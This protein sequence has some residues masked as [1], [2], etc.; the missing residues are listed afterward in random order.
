MYEAKAQKAEMKIQP[1]ETERL[2]DDYWGPH[3]SPD[4]THQWGFWVKNNNKKTPTKIQIGIL[5]CKLK[6][7]A[8]GAIR[9]FCCTLVGSAPAFTSG[10]LFCRW[11][12]YLPRLCLLLSPFKCPQRWV[13]NSASQLWD[14]DSPPWQAINPSA[15]SFISLTS[16]SLSRPLPILSPPRPQLGFFR[17]AVYYRIMPKHQGVKIRRAERYQFNLGFQPED[18]RK[19]YWITNWT[20]MQQYYYWGL[21][22]LGPWCT[23]CHAGLTWT[24]KRPLGLVKTHGQEAQCT[25]QLWIVFL[26]F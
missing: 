20:E 11:F 6:L 12:S 17:R 9:V 16:P 19:K 3:G 14:P 24:L 7:W 22:P 13:F 18:S 25:D 26:F 5:L 2:T 4:S 1:S 21:F 8:W 23:R 15:P 10:C